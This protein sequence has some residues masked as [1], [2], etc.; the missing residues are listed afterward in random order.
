MAHGA[1]ICYMESEGLYDVYRELKKEENIDYKNW[2]HFGD[3]RRADYK[4]PLKLGIN[5][6]RY[7]Y[8]KL[9]PY[10]KFDRSQLNILPLNER[11]HDVSIDII[12]DKNIQIGVNPFILTTFELRTNSTFSFLLSIS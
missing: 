7:K 5:A 9:M 10:E 1:K 8:V 3:N 6:E 12:K 11:I 2:W 4:R